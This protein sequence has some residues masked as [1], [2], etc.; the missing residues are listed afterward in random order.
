M[1]SALD[2]RLAAGG[3]SDSPA[4]AKVAVRERERRELL[5]SC[6]G[7]AS[8]PERVTD[9]TT[10]AAVLPGDDVIYKVTEI[11]SALSD[12]TRLKILSSLMVGELCVC[13]LV[14][15]CEVSQ[16][17]VSH[18][19]RLLRDRGLVRARR[20][21]QRSAYRLADEHVRMLIQIGIEHA[22]EQDL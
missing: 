5:D 15:I 21:G 17:A 3:S 16:S 13:E 12:S 18:Q 6:C 9:I 22:S 11:F 4:T 14:E 20:V 10:A 2:D 8:L 1:I 7:D 19:L